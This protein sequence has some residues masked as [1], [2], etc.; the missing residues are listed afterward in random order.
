MTTS[1]ATE[2][3]T[4]AAAL[5]AALATQ[6]VERVYSLPGGH[7]KPLWHALDRLG[8]RIVTARDEGAAV[9]MAQ[10]EADLSG[11]LAVAVLTAGPAVTNAVTGLGSALLARSPL[12]V[13]STRPPLL[14]DRMGALEEVDQVAVV[15]PVCRDVHAI[16]DARHVLPRLDLA[17]SAAIGDDGLPGPVYFELPADMLGAD[18]PR[19]YAQPRRRSRCKRAPQPADVEEAAELLRASRRP[20]VLSGREALAAPELV[21]RFVAAAGAVYLDTRASR[22]ATSARVSSFVPALRARAMAEAD[23][24]VTL[25]RTLD[26]ELAFGS[27]A[28]FR[29][30]RGFLRIGR[31]A[32][33]VTANRRGD[34]ELRGDV[35][36]ALEALLETGARP[37]DPD[38]EWLEAMVNENARRVGRLG[39]RIGEME[40][41]PDGM[42][43]YQLLAAV[44]ELVDEETI[45]IVDGGDILSWARSTIEAP[46]Y[47]DLGAFGCLGVGVPFAV[48]AALSQAG[49]RV[50]AVVGDGALGFNAMEIETAVREG[51]QILVVVANNS[52][53]NIERGDQLLN[54]GGEALGTELSSCD[55]SLLAR[56]LG[57][58]GERVEDR[59]EL[60]SALERAL[61]NAPA[62]VDVRVSREPVSADNNSGL[63]LVPPLQALVSWDAHE[64]AW[65]DRDRQDDERNPMTGVTIHQP[66]ER[67]APRGY[68]EAT[69][70]RGAI[71]AVSGQLPAPELLD[72][73]A[74]FKDQFLSALERVGEVLGSAGANV[75]DVILLR[76]YVTDLDA[77]KR[78][79]RDFGARYG[80]LLGGQF[81]ATTLVEVSGL[82]DERAL[83][84]IEALAIVP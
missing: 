19:A 54:Y 6:G 18:R 32:E 48:G 80:E 5:A 12:L 22:G 84:E 72:A 28:V 34:V 11:E 2:E 25:G 82:V 65:Q 64:R 39:R 74:D 58:H 4:V 45:V 55:Y 62:L 56:G 42:H 1:A 61:A 9:H 3:R 16:L 14:Q 52:A 51:A 47:L 21:P 50:I 7:M 44:N 77:Y 26:F 79:L 23:L 31:S 46:A 24:V 53:W 27:P 40:S 76:I 33:D 17:I 66:S 60:A 8:V 37:R 70:A 13:V 20:L 49:R 30:A 81:P 38:R 71:V 29:R 36:P 83:V 73:D 41:L 59:A 78:G 35:G 10:A 67:E 63:P 75:T 43:P 57:A 15:K 69:S 68:S